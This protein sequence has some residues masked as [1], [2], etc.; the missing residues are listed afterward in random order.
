M[1]LQR[2]STLLEPKFH[3]VRV[4]IFGIFYYLPTSQENA[5]ELHLEYGNKVFYGTIK[6]AMKKEH[7][8]NTRN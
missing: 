2:E 5:E 4:D 1:Y 3:F 8:E 6:E 7:Q